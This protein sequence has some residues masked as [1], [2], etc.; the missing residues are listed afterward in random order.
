MPVRLPS[1]WPAPLV[2]TVPRTGPRAVA[3]YA[4]ATQAQWCVYNTVLVGYQCVW[5]GR[6]RE[7]TD[8][9]TTVQGAVVTLIL[10]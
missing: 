3:G 8:Y 6:R 7:G 4:E 10:I 1:G 5:N 2:Y 9:D